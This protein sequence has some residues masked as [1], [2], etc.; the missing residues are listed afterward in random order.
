MIFYFQPINNVDMS[1][2]INNYI[3]IYT[4]NLST[5]QI[6]IRHRQKFLYRDLTADPVSLLVTLTL[7]I[8]I[9]RGGFTFISALQTKEMT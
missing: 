2:G 1:F 3:Y 4:S 6:I 7:I 8:Y 5:V 9:Y